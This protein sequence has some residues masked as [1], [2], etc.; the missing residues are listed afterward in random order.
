M[1][2][3]IEE[4]INTVLQLGKD[5]KFF[6]AECLCND[7][8][9]QDSNNSTVL[10]LLGLLKYKNKQRKQGISLIKKALEISSTATLYVDLGKLYIEENDFVNAELCCQKAI[11]LDTNNYDAWFYLAFSLK[12]NGK[13]DEAIAA[14]Q[15]AL[16]LNPEAY[17]VYHNIGNIYHNIKND[18]A[19][20]LEYYEKFLEYQP[21]NTDAKSCI[22]TLY[23]KMKNY[24]E[25]WKYLEYSPNKEQAVLDRASMPNSPLKFKP[26]WE[27]EDLT[28]KTIYVYYNGGYGDTIM[29]S[30]FL[31]L[32]KKKCAKVLFRPPN[33]LINLFKDCNPNVQILDENDL[34]SELEFDFHIP[35]MSLPHRLKIH[36]EEDIPSSEGY[37]NANPEKIKHYK[38][39]YFSNKLKI[40]IKWQG[41]TTYDTTRKFTLESFYKLFSL[42]DIKF[43]SIQKG[44]G[45]EQLAQ[46]SKYEIIDL[47]STFKD[48]SD[49]AAAIENL[50]LVICNDTSVAHLA[51]ALG[52][53]CWVLLPFVQDWRW[54]ID[55]G[56][57]PWYKSIK[58]FK[59]TQLGEWD[60][61][62]D[63]VYEELK[64]LSSTFEVN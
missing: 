34:E 16:D 12:I 30:R 58:L 20:T 43:Y 17:N 37:I 8:L 13:I 47:G 7:I 31:P 48:F 59:Q 40:G 11:E 19:R 56:Y 55:T 27:G 62:F 39:K 54:S 32:L 22:G 36:S 38:D 63:K 24:K 33:D 9:E 45:A 57:C 51:G 29:F 46:A 10:T 50:D 23:L 15:K 28:D 1:G 61:I 2:I 14:Y 53:Q 52:K 18:P 44:E 25:G 5:E 42:P 35:I 60:G 6:E 3:N 41:D 49:T 4:Q 64:N 26:L 21:E